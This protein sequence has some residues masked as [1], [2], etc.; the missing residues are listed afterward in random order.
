MNK[1]LDEDFIKNENNHI[2]LG[3]F[4]EPDEIAKTIFFVADTATYLND[5]IIKLDGGRC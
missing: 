2:L 4:A 3:R 1:E 5:S